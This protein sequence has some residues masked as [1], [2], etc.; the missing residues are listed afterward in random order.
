MRN[1]IS[2]SGPPLCMCFIHSEIGQDPEVDPEDMVLDADTEYSSNF[3]AVGSIT[4]EIQIWVS[5]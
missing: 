2:L 3:V 5:D 4:N 1:D